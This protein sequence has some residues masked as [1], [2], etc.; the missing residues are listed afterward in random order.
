MPD[1]P[2]NVL[3][4]AL[5][6][7]NQN[8]ETTAGVISHFNAAVKKRSFSAADF[9]CPVDDISLK[10]GKQNVAGNSAIETP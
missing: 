2:Q 8:G 7:A 3:R 6:L 9:F 5:R 1:I 10:R 4:A